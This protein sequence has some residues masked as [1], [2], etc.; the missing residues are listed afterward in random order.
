MVAVALTVASVWL[1]ATLDTAVFATN[2]V[3]DRAREMVLSTLAA[4]VAA[5]FGEPALQAL[6]SNGLLGLVL[7]AAVLLAAALMAAG[8]LRAFAVS[9]RR[10]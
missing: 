3:L 6:R 8:A 5:A 1:L 7:A 4:A 10:R 9:P 2:L